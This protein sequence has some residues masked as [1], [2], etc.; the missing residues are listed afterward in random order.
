MAPVGQLRTHSR[1]PTHLSMSTMGRFVF[2][3]DGAEL[4]ALFALAAADAALCAGLAHGATLLHRAAAQDGALAVGLQAQDGLGAD[5]DALA[6]A[7]ALV[8]VDV[9]EAVFHVRAPKSGDLAQEP[10][11][12]QEYLQ[13]L[14]PA[15]GEEERAALGQP[16]VGELDLAGIRVA[17]A[18]DGGD[19][20][21]GGP[22]L[23]AHDGGDFPG[24]LFAADGQRLTGAPSLTTAAA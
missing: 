16:L 5:L 20:A 3:G 19:H 7:L 23:H 6:A 12:R 9:D 8:R 17:L 11:P 2:H 15:G 4:T 22:R 14:V 10:R 24:D 13:A 18:E 21:G 1:H